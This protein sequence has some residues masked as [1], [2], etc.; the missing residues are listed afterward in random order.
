MKN[1]LLGIIAI[2]LTFISINL[3][4]RSVEPAYAANSNAEALVWATCYGGI[5]S[6]GVPFQFSD[7]EICRDIA[8]KR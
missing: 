1:L 6:A 8:Y 7:V 2:N 4:L 3:T 5:V